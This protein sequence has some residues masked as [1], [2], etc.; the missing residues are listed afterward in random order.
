MRALFRGER[1]GSLGVVLGLFGLSCALI[2]S[3]G[4]AWHYG[5]ELA[6]LKSVIVIACDQR[7]VQDDAITAAARQDVR[8]FRRQAELS[9]VAA[10]LPPAQQAERTRLFEEQAATNQRVVDAKPT[11]KCSD[12]R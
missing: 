8:T 2:V 7:S 11:R 1:R 12:Y 6:R 9:R 5:Q 4:L 3:I 10:N